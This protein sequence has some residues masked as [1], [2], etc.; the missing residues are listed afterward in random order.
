MEAQQKKTIFAIAA[1]IGY[2]DNISQILQAAIGQT[3][4]IDHLTHMEAN[5]CIKH[6]KSIQYNL[7][8]PMQRKVTHL[9]CLAG[10]IKEDG[11]PDYQRQD[12][13]IKTIGSR[14][15]KQKPLKWLGYKETLDVLNQVD[16]IVKKE[17]NRNQ[18]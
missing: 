8:Q 13:F 1:D 16:V 12:I 6:L 9:L 3:K 18:S 14:N 5:L 10:M 7:V 2:Q 15:P 4:K 17:L 11:K